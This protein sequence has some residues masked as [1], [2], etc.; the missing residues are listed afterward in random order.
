MRTINIGKL[1]KRITFLAYNE[2]DDE[3]GQKTQDLKVVKTVWGSLYPTRGYEYYEAQKLRAKTTF[4][5]YVRYIPDITNDNYIKYK[6][7]FY[8]IESVNNVDME[9]KILE[10]YATEY[11]NSEEMIVNE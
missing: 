7:K 10:I 4:K 2:V 1:N 6:D 3:L 11:L 8:A 9:N 5:V